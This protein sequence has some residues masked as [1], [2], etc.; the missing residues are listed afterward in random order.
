VDRA[1]ASERAIGYR[2]A[3]YLEEELRNA[4]VV[5]DHSHLTVD[6]EYNRNLGDRKSLRGKDERIAEIVYAARRNALEA[7][8]EGF[9]TFSTAPDLIVHQRRTNDRNILVIEIKKRSNHET[10]EYDNLKL[11]LFTQPREGDR[12]YGYK[13]GAW[14]VAEDESPPD[15]RE[16]RVVKRFVAGVGEQLA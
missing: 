11:K 1:G 7:D 10:E 13:L 3:F 4:G 14:I 2:L 5:D 15:Q 9:Y 8:E 6:C 12:G 16:L